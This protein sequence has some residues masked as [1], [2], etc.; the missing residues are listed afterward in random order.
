MYKM[1]IITRGL[2]FI[3]ALFF[4]M[5]A[6]GSAE[7]AENT[8]LKATSKASPKAAPKEDPQYSGVLKIIEATGPKS[9]F[10]WPV[11]GIGEASVAQKPCIESLLRQHY[12]GRI[13]PWLAESWVIAPDK[14]SI[15]FKIRKGVKFHDGTD[16]NAEA[17]KFNLEAM[18][19]GKRAGTEDWKSIDVID[20]YALKITFSK[21][22]NLVL[23][24][25][26]GGGGTMVSP[27]AFKTKGIEWA[28]WNP[29]GTGPFQFVSFERDVRLKYKK[30]EEY[31]QKG[32]PYLDGVE[33][34]Y[35]KDPMTQ[36][37]SMQAGEAH[38]LNTE[39]G[40]MAADL[41]ASG[42]NVITADTGTV[43]FIPDSNNPE[44]PLSVKKVREAIE[45][46]IDK[47]AIAK[48][49][50]YGFWVAAYQLPPPGTM[51]FMKNFKGR[52]YDPAKAKQLLSE[53]GYAKGFKIK[54]APHF[55]IDRDIMVSIQN[56][57]GKVGI[58]VEIEVVDQGKYT[59]Y[60][61]KGYKNGFL[62]QPFG[63]YPN[64][65]QTLS[66]YLEADALDFPTT[67]KPD[68]VDS[69][70]KDA[71]ATVNPEFTRIEKVLKLVNDD[72]TV[73]PIH[74]TGRASVQQKNVHNTGH[75]S[76]G[77]W[78]EWAPEQAWLSK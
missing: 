33:Y 15:T 32:K 44:S 37:A 12:N 72:I 53:A 28:R 1:K 71:L 4:S 47:E 75:L 78:T 13:E 49:K 22:T 10:G 76:L 55:A 31:W 52:K 7:T 65:L 3:L 2:S 6:A 48:A 61:R 5:L 25:F 64:F 77:L 16:F 74:T 58:S 56:Y 26:A 36:S 38:V 66:L 73:I 20:E 29:V 42:L 8:A 67:K 18:K 27:T 34:I 45:Y 17:A 59:D 62:C 68:G 19:A 21:Y 40:K 11:E 51:A 50:S 46:A 57:L 35:I 54:I 30:F 69:S 9:P 60:R 23:T 14:S 70:L 43:V 41:K 24:R 39:T 63:M